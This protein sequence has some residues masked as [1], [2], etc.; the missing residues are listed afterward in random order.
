VLNLLSNAADACQQ[1]GG[2]VTVST[3]QENDRVAIAIKDTG[4]GIQPGQM[5]LLFQSFY[6]TKPEV[7]GTDLGL[8]VCH[9]IV[10]NHQGE[11]RVES[12]P[13]K[14]ATFTVFLP[15]QAD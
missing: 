10:K 7:K 14:G 8:S 15:I 5:E 1:S 9:G 6:T 4:I 11:I 12:Q 13:Q 2:V 3:W